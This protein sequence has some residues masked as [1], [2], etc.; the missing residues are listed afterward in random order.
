MKDGDA[1]G[2]CRTPD[3]SPTTR[4]PNT[5][6]MRKPLIALATAAALVVYAAQVQLPPNLS[7]HAAK[8][9]EA[10]GLKAKVLVNEVGGAQTTIEV[11]YAKPNL[12][13]IDSPT[14]LVVGDGKTLTVLD[15]AK[16]SYTETPYDQ[17]TAVKQADQV[18]AWA[19]ASFFQPD[20]AKLFKTAKAGA[21]RKLRGVD[22]S[23]AEVGLIDGKST[24][25]IYIETKTGLARGYQ[26]TQEGKQFIVWAETVEVT[27]VPAEAF[28]FTAPAGATKVEPGAVADVAWAQVATVFTRNCMPCHAAATKAGTLDLTTY[29]TVATHRFVVKGEAN[30]S[31]LARSLRASGP[32]RMPQGR[33]PLPEAQIKLIEDWI[34]GGMKQ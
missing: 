20:P 3:Q 10:Q 26:L 24:A 17:E 30:N 16:N 14:R 7:G 27:A 19:W 32:K 8:L 1:R 13:K 29:Q 2:A 28:A 21:A 15:K 33:P 31:I 23:E 25:T 5:H 11:A 4:Y 6:K 18:G 12:I 22:V 9:K 34:N